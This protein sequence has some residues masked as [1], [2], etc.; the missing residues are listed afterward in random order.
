MKLNKLF[1]LMLALPLAM[2]ACN[3]TTESKPAPEAEY[4]V[5]VEMTSAQRIRVIPEVNVTLPDY[6]YMIL[7]QSRPPLP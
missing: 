6:Q 1:I 3:K 7:L 5:D 4:S 2:V